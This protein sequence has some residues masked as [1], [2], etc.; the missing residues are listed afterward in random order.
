[1]L[2]PEQIS[3]AQVQ[4]RDAAAEG[5]FGEVMEIEFGG[6]VCTLAVRLCGDPGSLRSGPQGGTESDRRLLLRRLSSDVPP[7]GAIVRI[8][9]VGAAHVFADAD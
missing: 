5:S 8:T 9:V 6:S 7:V 3:L 2:R 1:M 4:D